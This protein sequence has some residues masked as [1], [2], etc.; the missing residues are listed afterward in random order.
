MRGILKNRHSLMRRV[1]R[2][3]FLLLFLTKAQKIRKIQ[4]LK[5]NKFKFYKKNQINNS[6][7]NKI[8][9]FKLKKKN[10]SKNRFKSQFKSNN[11]RIN[12][13]KFHKKRF[14]SEKKK[15]YLL[16]QEKYLMEQRDK[17]NKK[18]KGFSNN[19]IPDYRFSKQNILSFI[20]LFTCFLDAKIF[21]GKY[22][23]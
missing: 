4:L 1:F 9:L 7:I 20:L 18:I 5:R 8:E 14:Y 23:V 15:L 19:I 22:S 21:I 16:R 2:N 12:N 3:Q 11:L 6:K 17:L 13:K 10:I